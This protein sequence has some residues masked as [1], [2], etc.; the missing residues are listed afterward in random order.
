MYH[1]VVEIFQ[2]RG[3]SDQLQGYPGAT[4]TNNTKTIIYSNIIYATKIGKLNVLVQPDLKLECELPG[5]RLLTDRIFLD[6]N[7]WITY[8]H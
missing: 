1:P 2:W 7:P 6:V 5:W 8:M 4:I 3:I